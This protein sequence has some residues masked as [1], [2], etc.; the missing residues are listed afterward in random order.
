MGLKN[1]LDILKYILLQ[2]ALH[3]DEEL[4]CPSQDPPPFIA[5]SLCLPLQELPCLYL[6]PVTVHV[7]T[8]SMVKLFLEAGRGVET[9]TSEAGL[10]WGLLGSII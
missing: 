3:G 5:G 9:D 8:I 1:L 7:A 2:R 10:R 4:V 6:V